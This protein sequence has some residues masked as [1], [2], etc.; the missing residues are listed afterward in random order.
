MSTAT[1]ES[2]IT[3]DSAIKLEW[4]RTDLK[5]SLPIVMKNDHPEL[6]EERGIP[7]ERSKISLSYI[8]VTIKPSTYRLF[9]SSYIWFRRASDG[10]MDVQIEKWKRVTCNS[11][12]SGEGTIRCR[13]CRYLF[14]SWQT[15]IVFLYFLTYQNETCALIRLKLHHLESPEKIY[16]GAENSQNCPYCWRPRWDQ[17]A[18]K[19]LSQE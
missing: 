14:H 5:V 7:P 6:R 2:A 17:H 19:C 13:H 15:M 18:V 1:F 16:L 10:S 3:L 9:H 8:L 12:V 4:S 11:S